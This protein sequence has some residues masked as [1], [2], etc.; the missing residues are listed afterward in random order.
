MPALQGY[1]RP[2]PDLFP[3]GNS[4]PGRAGRFQVVGRAALNPVTWGWLALAVALAVL[5]FRLGAAGDALLTWYNAD[6][7]FAIHIYKDVVLDGYPLSG[8]GYPPAPYWFPDIPLASVAMA[9][10]GGNPTVAMFLYGV[11][12][13]GLLVGGF[14]V[15]CRAA[16]LGRGR[17]FDVSL[18]LAT[19]G[20]ILMTSCQVHPG[21]APFF[22]LLLPAYHT[23]TYVVSLWC[24]A[25]GLWLLRRGAKGTRG[26]AVVSGYAALCLLGTLGDPL[27]LVYL[28]APLCA[29]AILG[30]FASL[31][32]PRRALLLALAGC[33]SAL[34]GTLLA[35]ALF[36]PH[37]VSRLSTVNLGTAC[38]CARVFFGGL[39]QHLGNGFVPFYWPPVA[40][41]AGCAA[42]VAHSVVRRPPPA[43]SRAGLPGA[44]LLPVLL[45]FLG[46]S[47][48]GTAAALIVG[49]N[50]HLRNPESFWFVPHYL[51]PLFFTA[52]FGLALLGARLVIALGRGEPR[53]LAWA[54]AASALVASL[55]A[56]AAGGAAARSP[57]R[58]QPDVVR[59]LDQHA[60]EFGLTEGISSY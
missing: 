34:G 49:G 20:L 57:H 58:Y 8:W 60:G 6:S 28:L 37:P 40:W 15:C 31:V 7:L 38:T 35:R 5:Y 12:Q 22:Y 16:G 50:L 1:Y 41:L 9:L 10:T 45:A 25:L 27:F 52:W 17:L 14:M 39:W 29:A 21:Y 32:R 42:A 51:Q 4:P 54:V 36:D 47:G 11:A 13:V 33:A 3:V 56:L 53:G 18:L 30:V 48:V 24:A 59:F 44:C 46:L 43:A 26:T 23:G 55:V 19:T 2:A